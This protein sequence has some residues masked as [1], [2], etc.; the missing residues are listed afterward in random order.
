MLDRIQIAYLQ[1]NLRPQV[2]AIEV[3]PY[4]VELQKQPSLAASGLGLMTPAT[5]SD[6]RSLNAPRERGKERQPLPPRQMLQ[7]GAQS[8]TWKASDDNEDSLEFSLY[9]KGEGESDWK[10]LE[11]KLTDTFYT[12]N[13]AA[14]P[15]GTYRLKVV[16]SDVPSNPYDKFLIGELISDPFV[17]ANASPQIDLTSNKVSGK[18][19]EMQFRARVLTGRIA[20]AEFSID[21]GEW[22]LVFPTDGIADS[23]QE[24]YK[25][26]TP[27]LSIGE[28]LIGIRASDGDGNTGTAKFIVKIP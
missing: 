22:N 27:E 3:L 17:I 14:L 12:M 13:A 7:P 26:I 5:A 11:K 6:G 28:H 16:A 8:F 4:G 10:L 21:G 2:T 9:F 20:T 1:Q 19:V 24:D 15:D 23:A 18:K 25:V